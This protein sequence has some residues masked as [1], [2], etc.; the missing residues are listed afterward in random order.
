SN[1]TATAGSDYTAASGTL[2]WAAGDTVAKTFTISITNDAVYESSETV[3]LTLSS[4]TGGASL[5]SP[6]AATLTIVNDDPPPAT[7]EVIVYQSSPVGGAPEIFA[8]SPDGSNQHNLT[9]NP[10]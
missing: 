7:G 1:G 6:A 2:S 3:K 4:P 9:N 8:M 10:A 5:G